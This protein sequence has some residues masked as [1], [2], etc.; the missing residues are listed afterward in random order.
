MSTKIEIDLMLG[1]LDALLPSWAA[2]YPEEIFI[3]MLDEALDYIAMSADPS[4][5]AHCIMRTGC[6]F[7]SSGEEACRRHYSR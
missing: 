3:R 7:P 2:Q 4:A 5:R 1:Q 6:L